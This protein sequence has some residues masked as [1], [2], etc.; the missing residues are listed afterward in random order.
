MCILT[1]SHSV[2][3]QTKC[4]TTQNIAKIVNNKLYKVTLHNHHVIHEINQNYMK[5]Q[6]IL[7]FFQIFKNSENIIQYHFYL[8]MFTRIFI[9]FIY[10][11]NPSQITNYFFGCNIANVY[12]DYILLGFQP[13][14]HII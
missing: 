6:E 11:C 10:T 8:Q 4:V 7:I 3:N 14:V 12:S 13:N 5:L 9:L 2:F 1:I